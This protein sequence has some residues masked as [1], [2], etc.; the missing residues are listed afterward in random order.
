MNWGFK[1]GSQEAVEKG[2]TCPRLSD[3]GYYGNM[4]AHGLH[5][6]H[7]SCPIHAAKADATVEVSF[8]TG[9][10]KG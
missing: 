4:K 3:T 9:E 8:R 2:C 1:P 6:V 5:V 10:D 7:E